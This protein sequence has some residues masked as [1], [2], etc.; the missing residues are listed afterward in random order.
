MS[1]SRR[2]RE[3]LADITSAIGRILTYTSEISYEEFL[4]D[5][6]TQDAVIRNLQVI[7]EATKKLSKSQKQSYPS[8]PWREMAGLRDRLV[9]EYFGINSEIVW[10]VAENDLPPIL[11]QIDALAS[12]AEG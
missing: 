8:L 2:D 4:L 11:P 7:G 3:Y 9:H 1:D 12:A 5:T 6:K 10:T